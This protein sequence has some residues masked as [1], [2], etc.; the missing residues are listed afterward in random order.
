MVGWVTPQASAA[1]PKCRSFASAS[2]SSSLSIKEMV[3]GNVVAKAVARRP[4]IAQ[5]GGHQ[6]VKSGI[7]ERDFMGNSVSISPYFLILLQ[8]CKA[9]LRSRPSPPIVRAIRWLYPLS[10]SLC[11]HVDGDVTLAGA[12]AERR[13]PF[14]MPESSYLTVAHS[15]RHPAIAPAYDAE[16]RCSLFELR[17][18]SR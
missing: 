14:W 9:S 2:S 18:P 16:C 15:D 4:E 10:P 8:G 5:T 1:R 3:P 13:D 11:N 6:Y 17:S 12:R 7:R